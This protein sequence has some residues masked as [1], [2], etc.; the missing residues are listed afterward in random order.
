MCRKMLGSNPGL[1]RLRY[2]NSD[3]LNT[4]QDSTPNLVKCDLLK[5]S[6]VYIEDTGFMLQR[7]LNKLILNFYHHWITMYYHGF[8]KIYICLRKCVPG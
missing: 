4:Q 3:A 6:L 2:R 8:K 1:L 5:P 7:N